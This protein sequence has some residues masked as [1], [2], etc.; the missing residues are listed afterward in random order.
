MAPNETDKYGGELI[1]EKGV[2]LTFCIFSS[3]IFK[4]NTKSVNGSYSC[5]IKNAKMWANTDSDDVDNLPKIVNVK[6]SNIKNSSS[7][8][9]S[10][11]TLKDV[12]SSF[13]SN[14]FDLSIDRIIYLLRTKTALGF[15]GRHFKKEELDINITLKV[16]DKDGKEKSKS[17]VFGYCFPE[18]FFS[19]GDIVDFE[20]F[21][22]DAASLSDRAKAKR[23]SDKCLKTSGMVS[24]SGKTYHYYAF[25]VPSRDLWIE[26]SKKY[27][28]LNESIDDTDLVLS[29]V[30]IKPGLF[31][32]TKGMPTGIELTPPSSGSM[33]YWKNLFILVE[34]DSFS[35]DI[36]RKSIPGRSQPSIKEI[37][38]EQFDDFAKWKQWLAKDK[39]PQIK[40][41]EI[42]QLE[43][44]KEFK[45]LR[46]IPDLKLD[47]IN[48]LKY[49]DEQE[50]GVAAIFH[51]LIGAKILH[52][53]F[54]LSEG[55]K[56]NYDFWGKYKISA[57]RLGENVRKDIGSL[58]VRDIVIEFKYDASSIIRDLEENLKYFIDMDLL[59]CWD[60]NE[61]KF[62]S[63]KINVEPIHTK[64][65]LYF[66]A[67]YWLEFPG[68]YDLG[69]QSKKPVLCLK[70]FIEDLKKR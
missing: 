22:H 14:I 34:N 69:P 45:E 64:D 7:D 43:R 17:V 31:V 9:F 46:K 24:I 18:E 32:S 26:I 8:T 70:R 37:A 19:K 23:L 62:A 47:R 39:T 63:N 40:Q 56:K 33:G 67:N 49:P 60:I 68:T 54:C 30:D 13:D 25:F 44:E 42:S 28:L 2:G 15:T 29:S 52:G 57:E 12:E 6:E 41:P 20:E 36:G 55:Y 48:F 65:V 50:A 66:G 38:K 16:I 4:L 53:Y 58:F 35:F 10:E 21:L 1:G 5:E 3:D 27:K 59:V 51:E 61:K 11:I